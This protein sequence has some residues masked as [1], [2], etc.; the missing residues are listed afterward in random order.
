MEKGPGLGL[1]PPTARTRRV[2]KM[3]D[4][5][6]FRSTPLNTLTVEKEMIS[7]LMNY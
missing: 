1:N 5:F 6:I 7:R 4:P 2:V 3:I